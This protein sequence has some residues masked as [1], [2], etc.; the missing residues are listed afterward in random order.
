MVK[1]FE[2]IEFGPHPHDP[3]GKAGKLFFDNGYGVSVVRFKMRAGAGY[4]SYTENDDEWELAV[5]RGTADSWD[6]D[7]STVITN[8]VLG[9]LSSD[10]V[11]N[12]MFTVQSLPPA[13]GE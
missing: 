2:D 1:K 12:V 10:D 4:G 3:S 9:N 11:T 5:L 6:I 8:D 13:G 7:T